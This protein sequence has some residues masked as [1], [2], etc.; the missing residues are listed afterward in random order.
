MMKKLY[1]S[2]KN[3]ILTGILGGVGEYL[4]LDPTLVR[5]IFLVLV[6]LT[7]FFPF[8]IIYLAAYFIIPQEEA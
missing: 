3:R 8:A 6:A 4:N 7:G 2:K 5:L 1:R